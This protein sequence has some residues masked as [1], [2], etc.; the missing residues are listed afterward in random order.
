MS[1]ECKAGVTPHTAW[2]P[3]IEARPN[4][5]SMEL[6]GKGGKVQ[7]ALSNNQTL[8]VL[9]THGDLKPMGI[10]HLTNTNHK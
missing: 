9:G 3:Q 1:G 4:L 10:S 6:E 7:R 8:R 5:V 2:Y